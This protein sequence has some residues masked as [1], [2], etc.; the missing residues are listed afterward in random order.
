I[1]SLGH[2]P[3]MMMKR[4]VILVNQHSHSSRNIQEFI[5]HVTQHSPSRF[6]FNYLVTFSWKWSKFSKNMAVKIIWILNY[7]HSGFAFYT[8]H[9]SKIFATMGY[10]YMMRHLTNNEAYMWR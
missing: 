9:L 1:S 8:R 7:L 3:Y 6:T 4:I 10:A 5:S 2:V